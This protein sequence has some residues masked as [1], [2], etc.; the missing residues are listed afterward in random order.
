MEDLMRKIRHL[1]AEEAKKINKDEPIFEENFFDLVADIEDR[2]A[3]GE[4]W[5]A[6]T[7]KEGFTV[8]AAEAEGYV[9]ALREVKETY[10]DF[11]KSFIVG[12]IKK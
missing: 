9:R 10:V 11:L 4:E 6:Q 7:K 8:N 2:L 5:L 3:Y 1:I 12:R